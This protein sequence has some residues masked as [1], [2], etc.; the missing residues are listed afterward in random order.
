LD[1][2][3]TLRE[4]LGGEPF[5]FG[6][7]GALKSTSIVE[8]RQLLENRKGTGGA[9]ILERGCYYYLMRRRYEKRGWTGRRSGL[10]KNRGGMAEGARKRSSFLLIEK[11]RDQKQKK[12]EV[13]SKLKGGKKKAKRSPVHKG[14]KKKGT[15]K[16]NEGQETG[17]CQ[18]EESKKPALGKGRRK[19]GRSCIQSHQRPL[20]T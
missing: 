6:R 19:E 16:N 10:Q 5:T 20:S 14:K 1:V 13:D 4:A 11:S 9:F 3:L 12:R 18:G 17:S 2:D 7:G 8:K 15:H